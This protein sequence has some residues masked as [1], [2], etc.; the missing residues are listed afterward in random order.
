MCLFSF[1]LCVCCNS[2]YFRLT[3]KYNFSV[4]LYSFSFFQTSFFDLNI[5]IISFIYISL[6]PFISYS[7]NLNFIYI[8]III[9]VYVLLLFMYK[10][11]RSSSL[12]DCFKIPLFQCFF[13]FNFKN[14]HII[15][16]FIYCFVFIYFYS[17]IH[18]K[19]NIKY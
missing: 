14:L 18:F 15:Q 9:I 1:L 13:L 19:I 7:I 12:Y 8:F 2:S 16:S 4:L 3:K 6:F 11:C 17:F 5:L 10:K